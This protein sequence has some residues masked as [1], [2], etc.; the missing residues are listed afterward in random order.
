MAF[1]IGA[2][3]MTR[4]VPIL[5]AVISLCCAAHAE[6]VL[7]EDKFDG[8]LAEGWT[9]LRENPA[10]WR[11][12]EN[13]LE[14]RIEPGN[15]WGGANDAKNVLVRS[16]PSV[17]KDGWTLM[18][19]VENVPTAQYEQVDLVCYFDDSHMVKIGLEL[20]D[21]QLSLV[22]GRE[23][24][25]KTRTLALLPITATAIGLRLDILGGKIRGKYRTTPT[26]DWRNAGECE[27]PAHG[28]PKASL[29]TY[30]GAPD[31]EHWAKI[32]DFIISSFTE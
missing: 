30:Q 23:E 6:T 2:I 32:R 15:M 26:E 21:G 27:L 13:S 4:A 20:V 1:N 19:N 3:D 10:A 29:Q 8:K 5:L 18:V 16:L 11:A 25:D 9:W 22:M 17:G 14:I 12:T 24:A 31:V 7:F 28:E